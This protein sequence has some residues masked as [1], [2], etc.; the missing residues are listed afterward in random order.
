MDNALGRVAQRI[1]VSRAKV[2]AGP[3]SPHQHW[4]Y[5][6]IAALLR[7]AGVDVEE[8][9]NWSK[10]PDGLGY[11]IFYYGEAASETKQLALH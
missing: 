11:F 2:L 9:C 8:V 4:N 3:P 6:S 10:A 5:S 1:F 7:S